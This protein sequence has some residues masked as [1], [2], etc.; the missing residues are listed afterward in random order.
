[1]VLFF[2]QS[3]NRRN[4]LS[5]LISFTKK[6]KLKYKKLNPTVWAEHFIQITLISYI[7]FAMQNFRN[8]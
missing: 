6:K 4:I 2:E 3:I 5:N 7:S 8:Y 1:M